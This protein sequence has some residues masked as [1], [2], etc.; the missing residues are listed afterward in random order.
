M[1]SKQQLFGSAI[2]GGSAGA[3]VMDAV[4]AGWTRAFDAGRPPDDQDEETQAI[5]AVVALLKR[6]APRLLHRTPSAV[7]GRAIHYV[8]G[9][10][11]A[12]AY[13]ALLP[14]GRPHALRGFAFGTLL[15]LLSDLL[16]IPL[17]KLGRPWARYSVT[18]RANALLSHWAYALVVEYCR[19]QSAKGSI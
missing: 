5:T 7:A 12:G 2:L 10:G 19:P 17:L 11:F 14:R 3:L 8:F 13:L 16:L 15:W 1:T 4:Q 18:Q 9:I 6:L